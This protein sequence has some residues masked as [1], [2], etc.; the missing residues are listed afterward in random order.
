MPLDSQI[1]V[2]SREQNVSPKLEGEF[3]A[4]DINVGT[5]RLCGDG[6]VQVPSLS[7]HCQTE[8]LWDRKFVFV[9]LFPAEFKL[10]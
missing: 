8:F 10:E 4:R 1:K 3:G 9:F 7:C 6:T 2:S 5:L